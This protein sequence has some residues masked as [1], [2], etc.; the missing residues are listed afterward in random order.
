MLTG[1]PTIIASTQDLL[2]LQKSQ[3]QTLGPIFLLGNHEMLSKLLKTSF[4]SDEVDTSPVDSTGRTKSF[5]CHYPGCDKCY[6]KSS[7]LKAHYRT[8]T[9]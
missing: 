9:G 2:A 8:H 1:L 5:V 4:E 3:Q 7:H 6:Y